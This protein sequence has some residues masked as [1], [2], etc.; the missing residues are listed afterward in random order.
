MQSAA[1]PADLRDELLSLLEADVTHHDSGQIGAETLIGGKTRELL[2]A[3]DA[4][5]MRLGPFLLTEKVAEGGMGAVYL[6]EREDSEFKQTVAV[7]MMRQVMPSA[8]AVERFRQERRLL[9]RLEHRNIARLIDGGMTDTGL[10]YLVMEYITGQPIHH[11]CEE[12]GL[13]LRDRLELFAKVCRAVGEAHRNLI[14]HRDLKASN[15]LVTTDG[16]PKLLDFGIAKVLDTEAFAQTPQTREMSRLMTPEFASPE[17]VRGEAVTTATDVYALGALLY[18]LLSGEY[19]YA[20]W[21]SDPLQLQN[22]ICHQ[23]PPPPS[24]AAKIKRRGGARELRGDLDAIVAKAL[25]KEPRHRYS[26]A[27]DFAEDIERYLRYQPVHARQGTTRYRLIKYLRRNVW[28]LSVTTAIAV[29]FVALIAN[30]TARLADKRDLANLQRVAAESAQAAAVGVA[31]FLVGMF[32]YANPEE[33]N[34]DTTAEEILDEAFHRLRSKGMENFLGGAPA[35]GRLFRIIGESYRSLG[36]WQKAI[37]A[38]LESSRA[39]QLAGAEHVKDQARVLLLNGQLLTELEQWELADAT[40]RQALQRAHD[41]E[42]LRAE[43]LAG[44]M[45][46]R[47]RRGEVT[48]ATRQGLF[49]AYGLAQTAPPHLSGLTHRLEQGLSA[50]YR[51]RHE[52]AA[53]EGWQRRAEQGRDQRSPV[54]RARLQLG[55]GQLQ[56]AMG[57]YA[58]AG[59]RFDAVIK[60]MESADDVGHFELAD[61]VYLRALCLTKMGDFGGAQA[62]Y[63]RAVALEERRTERGHGRYLSRALLGWAELLLA[64]G[65]ADLARTQYQRA[66]GVPEQVGGQLPVAE[67]SQLLTVRARL[68][69]SD[70]EWI[71]ADAVWQQRVQ[72]WQEQSVPNQHQLGL[73]QLARARCLQKLGQHEQAAVTLTL[74]A[75]AL[76]ESVGPMHPDY[77]FVRFEQLRLVGMPGSEGSRSELEKI[78]SVLSE[79]GLGD[80]AYAEFLEYYAQRQAAWGEGERAR[81]AAGLAARIRQ[82][83]QGMARQS[84]DLGYVLMYGSGTPLESSKSIH[85]ITAAECRLQC[86]TEVEF[87]CRAASFYEEMQICSLYNVVVDEISELKPGNENVLS[88]YFVRIDSAGYPAH[89]VGWVGPQ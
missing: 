26:G 76:R 51:S 62:A 87:D 14:V 75:Q 70:Q 46:L 54:E 57:K 55:Q 61:P 45:D 42:I 25:R 30:Y 38:W 47:L 73:A 16:E 63:S 36:L 85:H 21:R 13:I 18:Q 12:H 48:E 50:W 72:L 15:I 11:Y 77:G 8:S 5:G 65:R 10:P 64:V 27:L 67:H 1:C 56:L 69:E 19:P 31:D 37:D 2:Q 89:L 79:S 66:I 83:Q 43:V 35:V 68:F 33:E 4:T 88:D 74:A 40:L 41:D 39:W 82:V 84:L 3:G 20:A 52:F 24:Q 32:A 78:Y 6:A 22:A 86:S 29:T 17:Q 60:A 44:L 9:A 81:D 53:A 7:K 23:D 34:P 80:G 49:E 58:A 28:A 71:N 59:S